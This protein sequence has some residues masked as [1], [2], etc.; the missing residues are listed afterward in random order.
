[1]PSILI[2]DDDS[3][4]RDALAD[5]FGAAGYAVATAANG[6]EGLAC[7]DE[8][9]PNVVLLDMMM[10]VMGGREFLE[11]KRVHPTV[12]DV[13][14]IVSSASDHTVV[15]GAAAT[16]DKPCDVDRLLRVVARVVRAASAQRP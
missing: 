2:V 12:A 5:I 7:L 14:V 8:H 10:P 3:D 16:F 6:K 15:P 11:R 4:L 13:P 1:M 9:R